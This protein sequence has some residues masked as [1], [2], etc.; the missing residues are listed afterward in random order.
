MAP[1]PPPPFLNIIIKCLKKHKVTVY[2]K[3]NKNKKNKNKIKN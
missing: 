2:T 1:F 3:K